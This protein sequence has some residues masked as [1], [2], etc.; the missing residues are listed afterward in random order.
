ME[1]AHL[2]FQKS[3]LLDGKGGSK[4]VRKCTFLM[5]PKLGIR[6]ETLYGKGMQFEVHPPR[7]IVS[8]TLPS[9]PYPP[10]SLK[11][12]QIPNRPLPQLLIHNVRGS[13]IQIQHEKVFLTESPNS[14]ILVLNFFPSSK[15]WVKVYLR[16]KAW[17]S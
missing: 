1:S 9:S 15:S 11:P 12:P 6:Q 13:A 14:I 17:L 7:L 8:L 16:C 4:P 3:R 5:V 10:Y 2:K